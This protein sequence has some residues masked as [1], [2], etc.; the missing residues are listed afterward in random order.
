M[1]RKYFV[2]YAELETSL[3]F[4]STCDIFFCV[5]AKCC[6]E[7]FHGENR[8]PVHIYFDVFRLSL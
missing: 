2:L 3:R 1:R 8:V 7:L 4:Q 6:G 5:F